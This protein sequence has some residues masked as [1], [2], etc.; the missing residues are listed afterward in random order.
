MF[1]CVFMGHAHHSHGRHIGGAPT[2]SEK[3]SCLE[4][5]IF[6]LIIGVIALLCCVTKISDNHSQG[7]DVCDGIMPS[8]IFC[9]IFIGVGS[10][11]M[12]YF[13]NIQ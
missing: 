8:L 10:Y 11:F 2:M 9:L 7:V 12:F 1:M 6:F 3:E 4:L 5:G 13:L